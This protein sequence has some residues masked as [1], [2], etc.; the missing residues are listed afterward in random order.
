M[1]PGGKR[2]TMGRLGR[3][4]KSGG[5]Q[6]RRGS[7]GQTQRR[8]ALQNGGGKSISQTAMKERGG[9]SRSGKRNCP[10]NRFYHTGD[11]ERKCNQ[12]KRGKT[13]ILSESP[14]HVKKIKKKGKRGGNCGAEK[15]SGKGGS[16]SERNKRGERED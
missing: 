10:G 3:R 12:E 8:N 14:F 1:A 4:E 6:S 11:E 2:G 15:G 5:E 13:I 7:G 9:G 16:G